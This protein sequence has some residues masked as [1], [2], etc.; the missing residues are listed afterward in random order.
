M[1]RDP[2]DLLSFDENDLFSRLCRR[3]PPTAA[4]EAPDAGNSDSRASAFW[5]ARA[6]PTSGCCRDSHEWNGGAGCGMRGTPAS[7]GSPSVWMG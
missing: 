4:E 6:A 2:L 3:E 1:A 7:R 5:E